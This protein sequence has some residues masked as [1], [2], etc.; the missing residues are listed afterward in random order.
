MRVKGSVIVNF[1]KK[2][3]SV[4]FAV[5]SACFLLNTL[6]LLMFCMLI[7]HEWSFKTLNLQKWQKHFFSNFIVASHLLL[8]LRIELSVLVPY[9]LSVLTCVT[10]QKH[11]QPT[12]QLPR[13][14]F[15]PVSTHIT[16]GVDS[17][18]V[19]VPSLSVLYCDCSFTQ[20]VRVWRLIFALPVLFQLYITLRGVPVVGWVSL[21]EA[22]YRRVAAWLV[23][24]HLG[25]AF[26]LEHLCLALPDRKLL[27]GHLRGW[28]A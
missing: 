13:Q 22:W 7:W 19:A 20:P 26:P 4:R 8:L 24:T 23:S 18:N 27:N 2:H 15:T 11:G 12:S 21:Y 3:F 25:P 14:S 16:T 17:R 10:K 5:W 9:F 6:R 1:D 28:K